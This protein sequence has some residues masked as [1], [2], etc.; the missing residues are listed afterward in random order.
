MNQLNSPLERAQQFGFHAPLEIDPFLTKR[1][2]GFPLQRP[3]DGIST[4]LPPPGYATSR[5]NPFGNASQYM[6]AGFPGFAQIG[7]LIQQLIAALQQ[8]F[9]GA[10]GHQTQYT[11][12]TASSTG[13]P[14]LAFY[15]TEQGGQSTSAHFDSMFGHD[16]LL[17]SDS[18]AGGFRISTQVT[19]PATNGTTMNK[20]ATITSNYGQTHV[21][22]DN[23]GTATIAAGGQPLTIQAGQTL[24]L[25][26]GETVTE[27]IDGSLTV[28]NTNGEGATIN[29]TLKVNNGGVDVVTKAHNADLGGDL[30][31]QTAQPPTIM[32]PL[33]P[34]IDQSRHPLPSIWQQ[35]ADWS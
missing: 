35:Y 16:D 18:F 3:A 20:S 6:L 31:T 17:D 27:N 32:H 34:E 28:I 11:D 1:S 4:C 5:G 12:A 30:T 15:G 25:G 29:T 2:L 7:R 23:S 22:L 21:S 24:D 26:N 10:D 19:A 8:Y 33:Q 13:D 9:A 14:H